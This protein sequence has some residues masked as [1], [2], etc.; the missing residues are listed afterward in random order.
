MSP[1]E[2]NPRLLEKELVVRCKLHECEAACC[3][4]GVWID[5]L[6]AQKIVENAAIIIPEMRVEWQDPAKWFDDREDMDE[7]VPSGR[8]IHSRVVQN[9]KHYGGSAC[10]F[11]RVDHKCALQTAAQKNGKHP[12]VIKPFYCILHPLD[13]DE[14]GRITLDETGLL[15]DEPG[16]CL[17]PSKVKI[18]LVITFE[19]ELRYF[20]GD[21]IYE[22]LLLL[23][24]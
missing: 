23:V 9:E 17:R 18:P 3:V 10:I 13:L 4:Y 20:L 24:A 12:W 8:V 22:N 6:E 15:L 11:L 2:I 21:Q 16:S 19:S 7:H 5:S 14:K 1:F